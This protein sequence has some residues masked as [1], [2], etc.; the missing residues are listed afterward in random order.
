MKSFIFTKHYNMPMVASILLVAS[1]LKILFSD[2]WLIGLLMMIIGTVAHFASDHEPHVPV[3]APTPVPTM[4]K[5]V[6][7]VLLPIEWEAVFNEPVPSI[8]TS[9]IRSC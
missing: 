4:A 8:P 3:P 6:D 9:L 1:G 7:P 2:H 5:T